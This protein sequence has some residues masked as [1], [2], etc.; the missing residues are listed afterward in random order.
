M[1]NDAIYLQG[2]EK[3]GIEK[4]Y[5]NTIQFIAPLLQIRS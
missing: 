3:R 5:S 4:I 1:H 2:K